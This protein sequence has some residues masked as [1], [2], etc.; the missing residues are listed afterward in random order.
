MYVAYVDIDALNN[1]REKNHHDH[2]HYQVTLPTK[3]RLFQ[4][5]KC[6]LGE[7]VVAN[8]PPDL[9]YR[10]L[11]PSISSALDKLFAEIRLQVIVRISKLSTEGILT[12]SKK[13]DL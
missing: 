13:I 10:I 4:I 11:S 2:H 8:Y 9:T 5:R 7:T 12:I 3:V 1:Y 6:S